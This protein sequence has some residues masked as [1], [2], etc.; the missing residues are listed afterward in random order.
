MTFNH[1]DRMVEQVF[2]ICGSETKADIRADLEKTLSVELTLNRIWDG[3][4]IRQSNPNTLIILDSDDEEVAPNII[5]S[6]HQSITIPKISTLP[7]QSSLDNTPSSPLDEFNWDSDND[8]L[9]SPSALVSH[10]LSSKKKVSSIK[11]IDIDDLDNVNSSRS[12]KKQKQKEITADIPSYIWEWDDLDF[13]EIAGSSSNSTSRPISNPKDSSQ[14]KRERDEAKEER[15]QKKQKEQEEKKK[16]QESLKAEREAQKALKKLHE[17]ANKLKTNRN[18]VLPEMIVYLDSDFGSSSV[19]QVLQTQLGEKDVEVHILSR[20]APYTVSWKRK[21]QAEWDE[22]TQQFV[23]FGSTRIKDEAFVLV[24]VTIERL[25]DLMETNSLESFVD[26]IQE[27]AGNKQILMMLE[28]LEP[29]YK[30]KILVAGRQFQATVLENIQSTQ[31]VREEP[32]STQRPR[33]QPKKRTLQTLAE[34]GPTKEEIEKA[35]TLLQMMKDVM[36]VPTVDEA[37]SIEWLVS[38]TGNIGHRIYKARGATV[39]NGP[40]RAGADDEDIWSRMLQ[41]IQQCTPAVAKSI[42]QIYPTVE[43]LYRAYQLTSNQKEAEEM[44]ADIEVSRLGI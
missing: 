1:L 2:E 14:K 36:I 10:M 39:N 41:E 28:G 32:R 38:L 44:L 8:S 25:C 18:Q 30:K 22:G 29:Y 16:R 17:Q 11:V 33:K 15:A 19:G 20:P 40:A 35:L 21:Q 9:P 13:D 31:G 5:E 12:K 34:S 43:S 6:D 23:P 42:I 26:I 7:D 27:D 4:F 37:D 3:L 24:F